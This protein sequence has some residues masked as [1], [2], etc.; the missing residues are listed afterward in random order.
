LL[1]TT[2]PNAP[3]DPVYAK[4]AERYSGTQFDETLVGDAAVL[5]ELWVA[6]EDRLRDPP[7]DSGR[8]D[9][10][11]I[12]LVTTGEITREPP[13]ST[14]SKQHPMVG[15]DFS[16]ELHNETSMQSLSLFAY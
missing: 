13:F 9:P 2:Y 8:T 5:D 4:V 12:A 14:A 6:L 3:V 7:L 11:K 15:E 16:G 10:F 1:P